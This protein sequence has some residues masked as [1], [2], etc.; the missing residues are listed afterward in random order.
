MSPDVP[1]LPGGGKCAVNS[2]CDQAAFEFCDPADHKCKA[3]QPDC[4]ETAC[5]PDPV[6][7]SSCGDCD[8]T[9]LA[10]IAA[11][12]TPTPPATTPAPTTAVRPAKADLEA[13]YAVIIVAL[14]AVA[15]YLAIDRAEGAWG[16]G[17]ARKGPGDDGAKGDD[18]EEE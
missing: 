13:Y 7:G 12:P 16:T 6:C 14:A 9:V 11:T 15:T 4:T 17:A 8:R 5:G 18:D 10:N 1:L 3:C 2:D